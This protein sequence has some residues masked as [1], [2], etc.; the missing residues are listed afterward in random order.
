MAGP[1]FLVDVST[2]EAASCCSNVAKMLLLGMH[3]GSTLEKL[4]GHCR[5]RRTDIKKV[6]PDSLKGNAATVAQEP[7]TELGV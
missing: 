5:R 3:V 1:W 2:I 7:N 6:T 4:R